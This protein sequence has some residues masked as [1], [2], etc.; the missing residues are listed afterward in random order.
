[1]GEGSAGKNELVPKFSIG[2]FFSTW[3]LPSFFLTPS[4]GHTHGFA[5]AGTM[6]RARGVRRLSP[7]PGRPSGSATQAARGARFVRPADTDLWP[8]IDRHRRA[9]GPGRG[10]RGGAEGRGEHF[11]TLALSTHRPR[12]PGPHRRAVP[13]GEEVGARTAG[14]VLPFLASPAAA[15]PAAAAALA[16]PGPAPPAPAAPTVPGA[17]AA[18]APQPA[19]AA[20]APPAAAPAAARAPAPF[21]CSS[22]LLLARLFLRPPLLFLGLGISRASRCPAAAKAAPR[23][24][25]RPRTEGA[26]RRLLRLPSSRAARAAPSR[27]PR[28]PRL[29]GAGTQPLEARSRAGAAGSERERDAPEPEGKGGSRACFDSASLTRSGPAPARDDTGDSAWPRPPGDLT[30]AEPARMTS[31]PA[32]SQPPSSDVIWAPTLEGLYGLPFLKWAPLPIW[33]RL[34]LLDGL[35]TFMQ[36]RLRTIWYWKK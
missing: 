18:A 25:G 8:P 26:G 3:A 4:P 6:G 12:H 17:P 10:S 5:S 20:R 14:P 30:A 2:S 32:Q 27:P 19:A 36:L 28:P 1:M 34:K 33:G 29:P 16:A 13:V 35:L 31:R 21:S 23:G 15:A 9:W 7:A 22:P 24:A 11:L